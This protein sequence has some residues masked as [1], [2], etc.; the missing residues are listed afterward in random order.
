[1]PTPQRHH[2]F[3]P[4][5]IDLT[6]VNQRKRP[7]AIIAELDGSDIGVWRGGEIIDVDDTTFS[8]DIHTHNARTW[9]GTNIPVPQLIIVVSAKEYDPELPDDNGHRTLWI[10][11]DSTKY[12][13]LCDALDDASLP[14]TLP[15]VGDQLY[16]MHNGLAPANLHISVN[17][18]MLYIPQ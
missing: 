15:R 14:S 1:M 8:Q 17:W 10:P 13:A 4:S 12:H 7:R 18:K 9:R 16:V 2:F 3:D 5:P 11:R 6:R